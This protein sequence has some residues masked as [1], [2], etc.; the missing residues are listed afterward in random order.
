[1]ARSQSHYVCQSCGAVSAKWV[2][3][4]EACGGWN[5][6]IE[7]AQ[8]DAAPKGLARSGGAGR[9]LD[10]VELGAVTA[11][12]P[13]RV[14][15]IS[16]FDRVCGGG[17]VPGSALLIGGDPGIGKSTLLLQLV[18]KLAPN[19]T[20][21]YISGEEAVDPDPLARQA[22]GPVRRAD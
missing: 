15:G 17:L 18:C 16:E 4:C 1:M 10:F 20:C 6:L 5:T 12:L 22:A 9:K 7:E 2:G 14:S 3:R 21:A 8:P 19:M 11:D 13:R